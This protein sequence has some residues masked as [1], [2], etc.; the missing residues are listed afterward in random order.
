MQKD[1]NII[2]EVYQ[3]MFKIMIPAVVGIAAKVAIQMKNEKISI[4]RVIISFIAGIACAYFSYPLIEHYTSTRYLPALVGL[5]AI[6][7]E[8]ITE[9]AVYK[10]RIDIFIGVLIDAILEKL[11]GNK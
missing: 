11:R 3:F 5:S 7:G 2:D 10:F 4:G 9:Y 1:P 8:K 6:S